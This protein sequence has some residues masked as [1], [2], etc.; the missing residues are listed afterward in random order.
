MSALLGNARQRA[1][2][3]DTQSTQRLNTFEA[4]DRVVGPKGAAVSQHHQCSDPDTCGA[5]ECMVGS[6]EAA[7]S[8][9]QP[10]I[11]NQLFGHASST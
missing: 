2:L 11:L 9:H 10:L 4:L 8:Q 6:L 3:V 7:V 5:L 1:L